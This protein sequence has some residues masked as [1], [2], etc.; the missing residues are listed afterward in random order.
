M[1]N[2]IYTVDRE[3]IKVV[4]IS[5]ALGFLTLFIILSVFVFLIFLLISKTV[6]YIAW[7]LFGA[8]LLILYLLLALPLSQKYIE[9]LYLQL[10][11]DGIYINSG[12]I[13]KSRKFVP[14]NKIQSLQL[15]SGLIERHWGFS[16]IRIETAAGSLVSAMIPIAGLRNPEKIVEEIRM[17]MENRI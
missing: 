8:I 4:K 5:V 2:E 10:A 9:S 14:Y 15:T 13:N 12:I 17:R 3:Y 16:T 1:G 11:D 6:F 7:G